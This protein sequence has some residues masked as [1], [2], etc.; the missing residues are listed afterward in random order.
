MKISEEK[1]LKKRFGNLGL[2]L[3]DKAQN[4]IKELNQKTMFQKAEIKKRFLERSN[5]R[6]LR[7]RTHFTENYKHFLNQSLSTTLLKG[8]EKFLDLK[9]NLITNL[10]TSLFNLIKEKREENYSAY[11]KYLLNLINQV[12]KTMEKPQ[13]IELIFNDKDYNYFIKNFDK[14]SDLFKNPVEINKDRYDFLG[15]FKISLVGGVIS[16]DYTIDNLIDKNSSFIQMEI[17]KIINDSEIKV[18]E[19]EFED[20]IEE[21]KK[22]IAEYLIQYDQIQI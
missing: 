21:Q 20:F 13:D 1:E 4:E 7:L 12:K 6:S 10:T 22:R 14:I 3:I 17:S 8:K 19:K 11:I 9:N 5:E 15:G 18:T 16:Y 2:Y